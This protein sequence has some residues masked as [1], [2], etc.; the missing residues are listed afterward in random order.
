MLSKNNNILMKNTVYTLSKLFFY[1]FS[2]FAIVLTINSV[3]GFIEYKEWLDFSFIS[4]SENKESNFDFLVIQIPF[5]VQ[6]QFGW[7]LPVI[8]ASLYF[9]CYYFYA[10]KDFFALFVKED[11]FTEQSINRLNLFHKLNYFPAFVFLGR[12]FYPILNDGRA[13]GELIIIALIH[14]ALALLLLYYLDLV[15]K[16]YVIQ[17]ENDLTI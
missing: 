2:L 9:Y 14:L 10:L 13:D 6:I 15:K 5:T 3:L 12:A 16:G 7:I 4:F 8:I 17:Q 1:G 11:V